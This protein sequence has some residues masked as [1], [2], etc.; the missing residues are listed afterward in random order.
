MPCRAAARPQLNT[1]EPRVAS[2]ER[3]P[4]PRRAAGRLNGTADDHAASGPGQ[5]KQSRNRTPAHKWPRPQRL[6]QQLPS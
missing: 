2:E 3:L 1:P 5:L 4:M 6:L